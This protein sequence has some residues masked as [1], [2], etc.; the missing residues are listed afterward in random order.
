[1]RHGCISGSG[2]QVARNAPAAGAPIAGFSQPFRRLFQA[3][4]APTAPS[5]ALAE[6][7]AVIADARRG[8]SDAQPDDGNGSIP[9]GYT[10][11][12]Q[13]VIHDMTRSEF[14]DA[15]RGVSNRVSGVLDLDSLYAGGP[16]LCPHFYNPSSDPQDNGHLF[17]LGKTRPPTE[18]T[19]PAGLPFDL[20]RIDTGGRGMSTQ[21][22]A[23]CV[24][25]L[26]ADPRNDDNLVTAQLLVLFTSVHNRVASVLKKKR[27]LSGADSFAKARRFVLRC[28]RQIVLFD[29]AKRLVP[30]PFY[31]EIAKPV[32]DFIPPNG[33]F[34]P[35]EFVFGAARL[36]HAMSRREYT[37]N[38]FIRPGDGTL[39]QLLAFSSSNREAELPLPANWV[40]DWKHFF[41]IY[42][43]QPPQPA[44][45]LSPVLTPAMLDR[46]TGPGQTPASDKLAFRDLWR[47]YEVELPTG[48]ECAAELGTLIGHR[49]P[50]PVIAGEDMMP[51]REIQDRTLSLSKVLQDSPD[52][53]NATPLTYYLAQE[54]WMY[55][56]NGRYAGPLGAYILAVAFR[57][58][59]QKSSNPDDGT[60][61]PALAPRGIESMPQFIALLQKTDDELDAL[62]P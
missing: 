37:P 62:V 1:M 3:P 8:I 14:L 57:Y 41:E 7:L 48:Q 60:W 28:Y 23:R 17:Y 30:E 53:L 43:Q 5:A 54:A 42:P 13:F 12:G 52:F 15:G 59:L 45:R 10:Y 58:A 26:I 19:L 33:Q 6:K 38:A 50:I 21:N 61:D 40:L 29:Y 16:M 18:G 51:A 49:I 24:A 11:F 56:K 39:L 20:P 36:P 55:G 47:C 27:G 35:L 44:R 46:V 9:A 32:P 31:S 4:Q 2:A 25:P 34:L 22:P